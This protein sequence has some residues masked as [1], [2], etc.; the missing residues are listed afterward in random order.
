MINMGRLASRQAS[1][2]KLNKYFMIFILK[3]LR[4]IWCKGKTILGI[5]QYR[6]VGL[7]L[8]PNSKTT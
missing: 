7:F 4:I 3:W 2:T 5:L 6:K 8:K 1:L